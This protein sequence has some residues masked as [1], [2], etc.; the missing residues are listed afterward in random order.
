M[1]NAR[2]WNA[3]TDREGYGRVT[4]PDRYKGKRREVLECCQSVVRLTKRELESH[5]GWRLNRLDFFFL[6]KREANS[7]VLQQGDRHGI[8]MCVGL[9]FSIERHLA[10]A[11]ANPEFLPSYQPRE[12]PEWSTRFLGMIIEHAYLHEAAHALRGHFAYVQR[13]IGERVLD[14]QTRSLSRYLELDADVQALDMWQ[15]ITEAAGDFP[16]SDVLLEEL[17][18]QKVFTLRLLYQVLDSGNRPIKHHRTLS[19]PPPIH[20]ALMLCGAMRATAQERFGLSRGVLENA[21]RQASWESG[22]AAKTAGLAKDRW[23]GGSTGR[24]RGIQSY[25]RL[26]RYYLDAVE[27]KLDAFGA[28]LPDSLV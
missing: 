26:V 12:R 18:F 17:Y 7:V 25:Q 28:S 4:T 3:Y 22:V 9:P 14:E 5:F 20:R 1:A 27:P 13:P 16:K 10:G 2:F 8:G 24:R 15:S 23:W 6:D 19:H 11:M 21:Y